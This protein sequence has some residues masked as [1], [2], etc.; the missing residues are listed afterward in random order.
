MNKEKDLLG[1]ME[2]ANRALSGISEK[3]SMMQF[4]RDREAPS[5]ATIKEE[6]GSQDV[7]VHTLRAVAHEIRNPLVTVAGFARKL[8]TALDPNQG[9]ATAI[10]AVKAGYKVTVIDN[11]TARIAP[12]T[13]AK[14]VSELKDAGVMLHPSL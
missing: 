14:A 10:H 11:L 12:E 13:A 8:S 5:F 9:L 1:L 2:K 3:I 4:Q 6:R 7:V